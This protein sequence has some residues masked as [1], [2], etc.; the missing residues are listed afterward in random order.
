[1]Y[2]SRFLTWLLPIALL[3]CI[4]ASPAAAGSLSIRLVEAHNE[5]TAVASGLRDV[6][7]TLRQSL[8]Y[9]GF[10]LLGSSSM[11]LPAKG[12]ASLGSG[13]SVRCT[14]PQNSMSAVIM[15]NGKQVLST[16][17]NLRSNTPVIL[18]GFS[19]KRG[20]LLVLLVAR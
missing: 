13:F 7:G 16:S 17:L 18:G 14:G 15:R 19:S 12:T 4:S 2:L 9:K 5:S 10:D 8:P 6:A 1:M 11:G 20:R 3:L